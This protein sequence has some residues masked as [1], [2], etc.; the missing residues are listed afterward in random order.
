M[1]IDSCLYT[2]IF[3]YEFA[4]SLLDAC[5]ALMANVF[6]DMLRMCR[7]YPEYKARYMQL[8]LRVP[9]WDDQI[10]E[11]E[12]GAIRANFPFFEDATQR[13]FVHFVRSFFRHCDRVGEVRDISAFTFV[14]SFMV[15]ASANAQV[16]DCSFFDCSF[17][18]KNG[19]VMRIIRQTFANSIEDHVM[20][21]AGPTDPD[22]DPSDSISNVCLDDGGQE[23]LEKET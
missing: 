21:R 1:G 22:I 6:E 14:Q 11:R 16:R 3:Q 23:D 9:D 2:G 19:V 18:E 15:Q 20:F 4:V 8:V 10:V 13:S 7:R 5:I 17:V 12:L